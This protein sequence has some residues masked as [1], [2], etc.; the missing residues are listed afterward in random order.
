ME[1]SYLLL[2]LLC[3][4]ASGRSELQP[5]AEIR[6]LDG[7]KVLDNAAESVRA[8]Y[9]PPLRVWGTG[10]PRMEGGALWGTVSVLSWLGISKAL[11]HPVLV[12]YCL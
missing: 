7:Q 2:I 3:T 1:A 4:G 9:T 6:D 10:S 5:V 12:P 8:V 11:W